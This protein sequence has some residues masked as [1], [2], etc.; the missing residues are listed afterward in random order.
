MSKR[1]ERR[2]KWKEPQEPEVIVPVESARKETRKGLAGFYSRNFKILLIIP[3][4]MLVLSFSQIGF[5]IASTGDF[6]KKGVSLSGGVSITIPVSSDIGKSLEDIQSLIA[7]NFPENDIS[8][9][10][11]EQAGTLIAY[12]IEADIDGNNNEQLDSL[13]ASISRVL[14]MEL[15]EGDFSTEIIGSA[16]GTSF[17]KQAGM[18]LLMAFLLM[19]IVVFIY[20]RNFLPSFAIILAAFSDILVSLAIFNVLGMKLST[21]GIAGFLMLIG[22]SVDTNILLNTRVLKRE[23]GTTV[24]RILSAVKTGM[25]MQLTTIGALF[26]ALIFNQSEIIQQIMIILLIGLFVD[27]INTWLQNAAILRLYVDRKT[28]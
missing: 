7:S 11:I 17:F 27:M 8:V 2:K 23:E 20:F 19:G 15:V 9:R 10:A 26:V 22:Y 16:L 4:V 6:V 25:T 12:L 5:Q 14:N 28:K 3:I 18:A 21:A 13:L 1:A 24:D